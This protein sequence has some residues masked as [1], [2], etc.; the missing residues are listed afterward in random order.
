MVLLAGDVGGTNARVGVFHASG[1]RP[2]LDVARTYATADF[3]GLDAMLARFCADVGIAPGAVDAAV[4]G[5]AGPVQRNAATL[6][7]GAW[8]I[9]G[10]EVARRTGVSRVVLIND[11]LAMAWGVTVL[12]PGERIVLHAG[13][14]D[15]H[16]NAALI[17]AGT[18]LGEAHLHHADGR[19][20]PSPSEGGH[21]D[22]A[23]RT[24]REVQL[25]EFITARH[26]R[27]SYEHV[28]SGPGLVSLFHF[29]HAEPCAASG[30]P[31]PSPAQITAAALAGTCRACGE[32][33][34]LFVDILGAEAGNLALRSLATAGVF[35]G[36]GIAWKI[37]PALQDGRFVR[38]FLAKQPADDVVS[39]IPVYVIAHAEPGLLGAAV[40]AAQ[41]GLCG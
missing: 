5:V 41:P 32:A 8:R 19:L 3:A 38:A 22:F 4:F 20:L 9:D 35:V 30:P 34:G 2:A 25:L 39:Q 11:L 10:D 23:A 26:G 24:A 15:P 37:L 31:A 13:A 14:P 33:L 6:T 27:A 1:T 18:G 28:L 12:E 21:A 17:A 36:G 29:T 16:G 40:V 7:N